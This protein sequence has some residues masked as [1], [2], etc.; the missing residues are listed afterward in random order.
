MVNIYNRHRLNLLK[1]SQMS[2]L[3][4]LTL[5]TLLIQE[6]EAVEGALKLA[7]KS[8]RENGNNCL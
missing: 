4:T 7:K 6:G 5:F 8:Y 1:L 3:I 2:Y